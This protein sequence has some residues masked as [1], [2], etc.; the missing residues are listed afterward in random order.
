MTKHQFELANTLLD[1]LDSCLRECVSGC[2]NLDEVSNKLKKANNASVL[3]F[4]DQQFVDIAQKT[5]KKIERVLGVA[6]RSQRKRCD[7]SGVLYTDAEAALN[8]VEDF[9]SKKS[10]KHTS[11][12]CIG[13]TIF[14]S[15]GP[16]YGEADY[17]E[18]EVYNDVGEFYN[19]AIE[20]K[21]E[22]FSE[23][24]RFLDFS[25][26]VLYPSDTDKR[27]FRLVVCDETN[28]D[29]L[30]ERYPEEPRYIHLLDLKNL[31]DEQAEV[32][33]NN[34]SWNKKTAR[35]IA[36]E[37]VVNDL[38]RNAEKDRIEREAKLGFRTRI[39]DYYR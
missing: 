32:Q 30:S 11:T 17:S 20:P 38:I 2:G 3:L 35:V 22:Q 13:E 6:K 24:H 10:W 27:E 29:K 36:C 5:I 31:I 15:Y 16:K 37:K 9:L 4:T 39:F 25:P 8:E 14:Y 23:Y 21:R 7:S 34:P 18:F 26:V 33:R 12:Q 28:A 1:E 19:E